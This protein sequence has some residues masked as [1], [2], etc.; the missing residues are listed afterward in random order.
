MSLAK[1]IL[2]ITCAIGSATAA[3]AF[4]TFSTFTIDGLKD[5]PPAQ[6]IAAMQSINRHATTPLFMLV[7]FGTGA[8][9]ALLAIYCL[10]HLDEPAAK[11][12]LLAVTVYLAGV[13]VLTIGYHV[14]RNDHLAS[15]DPHHIASVDYWSTY[16]TQWVWMNHL[17]VIAPL[18]T[19]VILTASLAQTGSAI[20]TPQPAHDLAKMTPATQSHP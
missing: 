20:R 15:L 9:C 10:T 4:L 2:T 13:V 18:A 3:G 19:A 7:L 16:L 14:P 17:R 11:Q 5:L 1:Q 6:G 8:S 12:Q